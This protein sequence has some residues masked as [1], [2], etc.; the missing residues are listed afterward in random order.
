MRRLI[1]YQSCFFFLPGLSHDGEGRVQYLKHRYQDSPEE[2]YYYP[3]CS[4]F[5]YGWT[6]GLDPMYF[7]CPRHNGRR[8]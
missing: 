2:R 4:S 5:E 8:A 7:N 1:I 3:V 6:Y